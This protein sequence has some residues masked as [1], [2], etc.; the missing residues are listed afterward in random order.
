MK[1][2]LTGFKVGKLQLNKG[3]LLVLTAPGPISMETAKWLQSNFK[4]FL[5]KTKVIVLSDGLDLCKLSL[6]QR[7]KHALQSEMG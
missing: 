3:D 2:K 1:P 6:P 5:P 7:R 4:R